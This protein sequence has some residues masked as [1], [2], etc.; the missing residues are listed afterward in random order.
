MVF[1]AAA[2]GLPP[3]VRGLPSAFLLYGVLCT[4]GGLSPASA[5]DTLPPVVW[6]VP[7]GA[8]PPGIFMFFNLNVVCF[9]SLRHGINL[10][11]LCAST[12]YDAGI[13]IVCHGQLL[14]YDFFALRRRA[15][16]LYILS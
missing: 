11:D 3:S 13:V 6:L 2:E 15:D 5:G 1:P 4:G 10:F 8:S 14:F 9:I 16:F 12:F 7:E